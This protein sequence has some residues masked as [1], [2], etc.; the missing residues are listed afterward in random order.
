MHA[1]MNAWEWADLFA[2]EMR[3][4]RVRKW[5]DALFNQGLELYLHRGAEPPAAVA[6]EL[7]M[8]ALAYGSYAKIALFDMPLRA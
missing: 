5:H 1:M 8:Q 2:L 7:A 3:A 6:V 4:R